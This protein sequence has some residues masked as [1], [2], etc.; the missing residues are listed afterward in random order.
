MY[1][2]ILLGKQRKYCLLLNGPMTPI[3]CGFCLTHK[4]A[5]A[6]VLVSVYSAG[7][8]SCS[9]GWEHA[10]SVWRCPGDGDRCECGCENEHGADRRRMSLALQCSS[11]PPL[12]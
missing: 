1:L 3:H 6:C 10:D 8:G 5:R 4:V 12:H 9:A 2:C 11:G 7:V